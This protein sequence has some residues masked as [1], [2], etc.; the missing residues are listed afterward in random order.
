MLLP[1]VRFFVLAGL[2]PGLAFTPVATSAA[3]ADDGLLMRHTKDG[4][5]L[6]KPESGAWCGPIA[7]M[8]LFYDSSNSEASSLIDRG[9][10]ELVL[11]NLSW[12]RQKCPPADRLTLSVYRYGHAE[13]VK[14]ATFHW[15]THEKWGSTVQ[16]IAGE[17]PARPARRS[18]VVEAPGASAADQAYAR[19]MNSVKSDLAAS[20]A[21]Q[22]ELLE[23][24]RAAQN[25]LLD[26]HARAVLQRYSVENQGKMRELCFQ[27][28][29]GHAQILRLEQR[30]YGS[31]GYRKSFNDYVHHMTATRPKSRERERTRQC[32]YWFVD[33]LGK[34]STALK[35]AIADFSA[36]HRINE[37]DVHNAQMLELIYATGRGGKVNAAQAAYWGQQVKSRKESA[38]TP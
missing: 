28:F 18:V 34:R 11:K 9:L 13:R 10:A 17:T 33:Q 31:S 32:G 29:D 36:Y 20:R 38:A 16:P 35:Y 1:Q 23:K 5:E 30:Q 24:K 7:H 21:R 22:D 25:K 12:L 4:Y 19:I 37:G 8:D 14:S 26:L 27:I 6:H 15:I 2:M 3:E